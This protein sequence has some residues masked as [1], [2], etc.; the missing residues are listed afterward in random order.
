[1]LRN[2]FFFFCAHCI[3]IYFFLIYAA[4]GSN[5]PLR[6]RYIY[7]H[8]HIITDNSEPAG[9]A[10]PIGKSVSP[11]SFEARYEP[12]TRTKV[13]DIILCINPIYD[14]PYAAKQPLKQKCTPANMLSIIYPFILYDAK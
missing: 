1:M 3:I 2:R 5:L 10:S 7:A 9:A 4:T 13:I 12:G 6:F 11:N 14:F 8:T